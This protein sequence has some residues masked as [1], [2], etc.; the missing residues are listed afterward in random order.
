MEYT[1]RN[2]YINHLSKDLKRV[3]EN[4]H[5]VILSIHWG[6]NF[7]MDTTDEQIDFA[8]DALDMGVDSYSDMGHITF[9]V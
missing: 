2:Q 4:N 8:H 6:K 9:M 5:L 1:N 7:T 3:R